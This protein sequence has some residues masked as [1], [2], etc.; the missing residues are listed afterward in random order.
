MQKDC[1]S[2]TLEDSPKKKRSTKI[3]FFFKLVKCTIKFAIYETK[4]TGKISPE[5]YL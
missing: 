3:C 1:I 4:D 2:I 5:N